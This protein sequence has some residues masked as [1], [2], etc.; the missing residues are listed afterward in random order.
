MAGC[1]IDWALFPS[2]QRFSVFSFQ[3]EP[4]TQDNLAK[5]QIIVRSNNQDL[6]GYAVPPLNINVLRGTVVYFHGNGE[7]AHQSATVHAGQWQRENY[8][9]VFA[10]YP[11][12]GGS[13]G[14]ILS[15]QDVIAAGQAF[16]DFA[17]TLP[18]GSTEGLILWGWSIGTSIAMRLAA[19]NADAVSRT[20]LHAPYYS[21]DS[22]VQNRTAGCCICCTRALKYHLETHRD[23]IRFAQQ[24]P[25]KDVLLIHAAR[26]DII[27][28]EQ[29][30]QLFQSYQ[31]AT[32]GSA[33]N[34]RQNVQL[35]KLIPEDPSLPDTYFCFDC[36]YEHEL[37]RFWH[38][39]LPPK[40]HTNL[41]IPANTLTP[42]Q[43]G[44]GLF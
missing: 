1:L 3:D 23:L 37:S 13:E 44:L 8:C 22:L 9:S 34:T 33:S 10:T 15:E 43:Q 30:E 19:N 16:I 5:Y 7:T 14:T 38:H 41:L 12:Y 21:I 35:Y 17:K 42:V 4:S 36:G 32:E 27:P 18:K 24:N 39:Y 40:W 26:D 31:A 25:Q 29:S 11:G 28:F 2:Q 20:V 6:I